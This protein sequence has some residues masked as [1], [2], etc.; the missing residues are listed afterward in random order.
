MMPQAK[1]LMVQILAIEAM[2]LARLTSFALQKAD[3]VMFLEY[4][5]ANRN[6]FWRLDKHNSAIFIRQAES[7][8]FRHERAD[9][10]RRK[11]DNT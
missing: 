3:A 8:N 11:I 6:F 10:A 5:P 2:R 1:M 4:T 7:E 9:L